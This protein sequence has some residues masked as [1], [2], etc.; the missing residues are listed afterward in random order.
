MSFPPQGNKADV[1]SL[2]TLTNQTTLL[3]RL[4]AARAGY[5][6]HLNRNRP[7]MIFPS[8]ASDAAAAIVVLPA[9]AADLDFPS[10]VIADLPSGLTIARADL[11]LVTGALFDTSSAENQV[12]QAAKTIRVK[13]STGAWA[14]PA[15][16]IAALTFALNALQTAA[17]GTRGGPALFGGIDISSI[18]TGNGTYNF[19]SEETNNGEGVTVTGASLEMHDVFS[20]IRVWYN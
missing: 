14:T 9:V 16:Q 3:T 19:R 18:V 13:L 15:D 2:A 10:V 11:V 7:D 4:S 8:L 1:S 5:M 6:D 20:I 17:D 12:D